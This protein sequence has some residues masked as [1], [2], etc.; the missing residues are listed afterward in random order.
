MKSNGKLA[1]IVNGDQDRAFDL[2]RQPD[3]LYLYVKCSDSKNHSKIVKIKV[4]DVLYQ[5]WVKI[6]HI[7]KESLLK[8]IGQL[9]AADKVKP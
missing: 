8:Y 7:E 2:V 1:E 9:A 4:S 6:S 3:A 5:V